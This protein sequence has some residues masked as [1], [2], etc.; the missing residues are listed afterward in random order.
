MPTPARRRALA[1]LAL[2]ASAVL[3]T[4]A[5]ALAQP[6][7]DRVPADSVLYVGWAGASSL[8]G[9]YEGSNL[10][11]VVAASHLPEAFGQFAPAL[12]RR[13]GADDV[14]AAQAMRVAYD[15]LGTGFDRPAA[16]VVEG[17]DLDARPEPTV[18]LSLTVDAGA[19]A[20]ATLER[21]QSLLLIAGANRSPTPVRA[22]KLGTL[23]TL[24]VG[25][26]PGEMALAGGNDGR[27]PEP[28]SADAGFRRA[29]AQVGGGAGGTGGPAF[30]VRLDHDRVLSI[31]DE[32]VKNGPDPDAKQWWPLVRDAAGVGGFHQLVVAGGFDGKDW[33]TRTFVDAPAPRKGLL[34][35]L[36]EGPFDDSVLDAVPASATSVRALR[37][38]PAR[39]VDVLREVANGVSTDLSEPFELQLD[40]AA[41]AL[42]AELE[43]DVLKPLGDHWVAY[44]APDVGG[45]GLLGTVVVNRLDDEKAARAGLAK[46]RDYAA[47]KLEELG[48]DGP[49]ADRLTFRGKAYAVPVAGGAS[50]A[51]GA[52]G[53][54]ED[55]YYL[56]VPFVAPAY[57]VHEGR[58]FLGLYPQSVA[59]AMSA[60]DDVAGGVGGAASI[61]QSDKFKAV[62]ERLGKTATA[63]LSYVD[64]PA[65]AGP[66]YQGYQQLIRLGVGVAGV[67]G[68]DTPPPVL[69]PLR[70]VLANLSPEGSTA[71][72]DDDGYHSLRIQSFPGSGAL[73]LDEQAGL[74]G[75][76]LG[77]SILLPS[78]NRARE[79][80][81]RIKCASNM[82][83]IGQE[84][85]LYSNE[86]K[87][88]YP[89]DLGTLLA[90]QDV[91]PEVFVCPSGSSSA[92]PAGDFLKPDGTPDGPKLK[93]WVDANSDYTYLGAGRT[94]S[95]PAEDILLYEKPSDHDGDGMNML[96]GD[97]HVEFFTM[98]S[99]V[100]ELARQGVQ[101]GRP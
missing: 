95:S 65:L 37:L 71:W 94:N 64:S 49:P 58:L 44:S 20:D 10:E 41:D 99:A 66:F 50:G 16:L 3:A 79:T 45:T 72:V 59:S 83:Y 4:V 101:L 81:N 2:A 52:G 77:T 80:A 53:A 24:S 13:A 76:A 97:G 22:F 69:P 6:L 93:A 75:A 92:P 56:D 70:V 47:A 87:D 19:D 21:A 29:L 39:V 90:T 23:V 8:A 15:L 26:P 98:P 85:L 61:L 67:K 91:A 31:I 57:A 25:H 46:V 32:S 48:Q 54:T 42:D 86:H 11:G 33:A 1:P 89:P 17:L 36:P 68:I 78:L 88:Q 82:R 38:D 74:G 43:A 100:A 14:M 5:P 28:L 63:G 30:V 35:L 62:R 18:R 51:G 60:A 12:I 96:F 84:M 34:K 55:V 73:S 27:R 40:R 9:G 7:A